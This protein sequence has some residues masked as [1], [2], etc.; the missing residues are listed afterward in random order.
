MD[1]LRTLREEERDAVLDLARRYGAAN[2]R[3]FG[4]VA[5]GEATPKGDIDLLVERE[6]ARSLPDH[7]GLVLDLQ[8]LL[9]AHVEV[10]TEK[11]LNWYVREHL[12]RGRATVKDECV[13]LHRMLERYE[14]RGT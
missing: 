10:G 4:S 12:R 13:Y 6:S 9:G 2:V 8:D 3:V 7:A 5:R 1:T 14:G 11:S